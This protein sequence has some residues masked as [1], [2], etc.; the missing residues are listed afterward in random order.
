MQAVLEALQEAG[1]ERAYPASGQDLAAPLED[2]ESKGRV[3][4]VAC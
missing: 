3:F 2:P 1:F 4:F